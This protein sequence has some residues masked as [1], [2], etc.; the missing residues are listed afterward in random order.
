MLR[1]KCK[2][3]RHINNIDYGEMRADLLGNHFYKFRCQNTDCG[4]RNLI[5][6]KF[7]VIAIEDATTHETTEQIV[8]K[9]IIE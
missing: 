5:K 7:D 8:E 4:K 3:C 1:I 6:Y 2:H 9:K